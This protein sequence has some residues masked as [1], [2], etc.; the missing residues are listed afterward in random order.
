MKQWDEAREALAKGVEIMQN[1]LPRLDGSDLGPSWHDV[2][3]ADILMREAKELI[4]D[5]GAAEKKE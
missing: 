5:R 3:I 2:V 1:K 4:E